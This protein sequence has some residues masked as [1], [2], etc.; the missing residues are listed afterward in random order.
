LG[1]DCFVDRLDDPAPSEGGDL[2]SNLFFDLSDHNF[3][4]RDLAR[5]SR[6]GE[7]RALMRQARAKRVEVCEVC[8]HWS[9][10]FPSP[11]STSRPP[12]AAVLGDE[13]GAGR[14]GAWTE[15]RAR[16]G[17]LDRLT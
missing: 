13:F 3:S 15:G 10:S 4:G 16:P 12:P 14:S 11:S 7:A 8:G 2:A 9:L 6:G 17:L 1:I 5:L